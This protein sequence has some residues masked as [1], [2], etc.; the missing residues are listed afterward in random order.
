MD[1]DQRVYPE[2]EI[3]PLVEI[4]KKRILG[5]LGLRK[6]VQIEYYTRPPKSYWNFRRKFPTDAKDG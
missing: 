6:L 3:Q 1:S 2:D 4:V 5:K